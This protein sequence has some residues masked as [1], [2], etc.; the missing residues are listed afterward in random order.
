MLEIASLMGRVGDRQ[1]TAC[2]AQL[3]RMLLNFNRL[4]IGVL[5][6][7]GDAGDMVADP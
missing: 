4:H 2:I 1:L 5:H 3:A 6:A 7:V